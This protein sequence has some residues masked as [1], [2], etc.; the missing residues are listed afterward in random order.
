MAHFA[1][2]WHKA[3]TYNGSIENCV[4]HKPSWEKS[5]EGFSYANEGGDSGAKETKTA[6]CLYRMSEA[7]GW[8]IL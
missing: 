1:V 2:D 8:K 7:V 5:C 3:S 4:E 6:L